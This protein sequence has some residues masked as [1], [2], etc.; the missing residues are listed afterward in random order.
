MAKVKKS[1]QPP[2]NETDQDFSAKDEPSPSSNNI[3]S[4][5]QLKILVGLTLLA[6][7][8]W[9]T[10]SGVIYFMMF[11]DSAPQIANSPIVE[12]PT[13]APTPSVENR[14]LPT[15]TPVP[16]PTPQPT[17]T[18]THVVTFSL[19]NKDKIINAIKAT[20]NIRHLSL[21]HDE[22]GL[23]QD[24]PINALTRSELRQQW[25]GNSFD[26]AMLESI[27]AERQLYIALGLL[28]PKFDWGQ[29]VAYFSTQIILGYYSPEDKAMHL[30]AESVNISPEEELTF[31]HEYAHAMQDNYF[32]L[33]TLLKKEGASNDALLAMRAL[34]EGDATLVEALYARGKTAFTN[35]PSP[36]PKVEGISKALGIF[37]FFPYSMGADFVINLYI[38]GDYSWDKV[39][40]AYK[41]P[42]I[43][44]EQVMHPQ[45]YL[46]GEMPTPVTLPDLSSVLDSNWREIDR[47]VFGEI[48]F[49]VWLIDQV[50]DK[51]ALDGAEGWDGDTY[52][53]WVDQADHRLLVESSV[54][55]SE[56]E[57]RQFLEAFVS[58]MSL[59]HSHDGQ[60]STSDG[61]SGHPW[62]RWWKY[63]NDT[64]FINQQGKQIL[65]ILAPDKA[66]VNKVRSQFNGF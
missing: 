1:E 57:A 54:W 27:E 26:K 34:P 11:A 16:S 24:I 29:A 28:D 56:A 33:G 6:C 18:A 38:A 59:R 49:V 65:I 17:P 47:N 58:S 36:S 4:A 45:K 13:P 32:G 25:K 41:N 62:V 23:P 19:N 46:D 55:E 20:E 50:D 39:N 7:I 9:V 15:D 48:G 52:A 21:P 63:E 30:V 61:E 35:E 43:S 22:R 14:P 44:S 8:V 3:F 40:E 37:T 60:P 66:T 10:V 31:A 5:A 53:L 51:I 2:E 64:A 42:P 12:T